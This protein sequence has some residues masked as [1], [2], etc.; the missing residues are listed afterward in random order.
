MKIHSTDSHALIAANI[1]QCAR[2]TAVISELRRAVLSAIKTLDR[3]K[4]ACALNQFITTLK[5]DDTAEHDVM[6]AYLSNLGLCVLEYAVEQGVVLNEN[7]CATICEQHNTDLAYEVLAQYIEK[8]IDEKEQQIN[9]SA[10]RCRLIIEHIDQIY[11]NPNLKAKDMYSYFSMSHSHFCTTFKAYTGDTFT[12]F[13]TKLRIRKACELM[14]TTDKMNYE[15]AGAVGYEDPGYF[16][17]VFKK[18]TGLSPSEFRK[19]KNN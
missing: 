2:F 6:I 11:M 8:M 9:K 17:R 3:S 4:V 5:K 18:H 1:M 19:S 15:I 10:K 13:L 7:I 16:S 14:L 12:N